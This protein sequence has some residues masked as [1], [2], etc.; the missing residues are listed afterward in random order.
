MMII[1][2]TFAGATFFFVFNFEKKKYVEKP[3]EYWKT[4]KTQINSNKLNK[5]CKTKKAQGDAQTHGQKKN[6]GKKLVKNRK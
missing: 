5:N 3:L 4:R 6:I 2:F 1:V